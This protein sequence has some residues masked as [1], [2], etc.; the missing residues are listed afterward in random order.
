MFLVNS[1]RILPHSSLER[2]V[3][4]IAD[5]S[6]GTEYARQVF[7]GEYPSGIFKTVSVQAMLEA[8]PP[9]FF[10]RNTENLVA[11]AKQTGVQPVLMT[12]TYNTE[13]KLWFGTPGFQTA[14]D[15]HNDILRETARREDIPLI[16]LDA[17]FP[18]EKRYFKGDGIHVNADGARLKAQIVAEFLIERNLIPSG[19]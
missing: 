1:G 16:D 15:E 5:T 8:N 14:T 17:L 9:V 4:P 2:S 19:G 11:I 10:R 6:Y 3:D 18:K 13:F 12:F 7:A